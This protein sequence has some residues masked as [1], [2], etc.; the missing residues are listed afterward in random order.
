MC[1]HELCALMYE[2]TYVLLT[3]I[4]GGVLHSYLFITNP[5]FN[6]PSCS[7]LRQK[8]GNWNARM[9]RVA[10]PTDRSITLWIPITVH[11]KQK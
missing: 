9:S 4:P 3:N 1:K 8:R 7:P 2:L 11:G 6:Q 10:A 5:N